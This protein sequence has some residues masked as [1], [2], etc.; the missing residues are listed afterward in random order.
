M[1]EEPQLDATSVPVTDIYNNVD[2]VVIRITED[3][4]RLILGDYESRIRERRSWLAPLG[5]L[6]T[7]LA[8]LTTGTANGFLLPEEWWLPVYLT[9][10]LSALVWLIASLL[11]ARSRVTLEEVVQSIKEGKLAKD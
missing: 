6:A 1:R 5:V 10:G 8:T 2:Q 7:I 4:L 9:A 11:K 3:R